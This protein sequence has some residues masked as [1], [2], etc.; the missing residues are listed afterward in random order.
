MTPAFAVTDDTIDQ[1]ID[2]A[3]VPLREAIKQALATESASMLEIMKLPLPSGEQWGVAV[4]VM[5]EPY[6]ILTA[7][8]IAN[9]IP[10]FQNS[11][12]KR[13]QK[14]PDDAPTGFGS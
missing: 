8:M 1:L 12:L 5:T 4:C 13:H 11:L 10:G 2:S 6:A 9:G 3:R 14:R 7:A